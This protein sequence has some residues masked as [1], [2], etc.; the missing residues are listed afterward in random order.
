MKST[1]GVSAF[2]RRLEDLIAEE[3]AG[4]DRVTLAYSGG[5]AST[6]VAMVARKRT[7]LEC[8]VAGV[9]GSP[10]IRTAKIAKDFLDYRMEYILLD[11]RETRRIHERLGVV[12]PRL[13]PRDRE[14]LVP[15]H[16][17]LERTRGRLVMCGFGSPRLQEDVAAA[18]RRAEVSAPLQVLAR[19]RALPRAILRA[20]ATALGLPSEWARTPHR[21]PGVGAGIDHLLHETPRESS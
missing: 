11:P 4:R 14:T 8:I 12:Y 7:D 20:A 17:V 21:A 16:A 6:L 19:G 5:L 10:D 2:V 13:S 15:I 3:V 18:L 1:R 9:D